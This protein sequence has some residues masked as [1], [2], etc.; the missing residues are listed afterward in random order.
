[1]LSYRHFKASDLPFMTRFNQDEEALAMLNMPAFET[2]TEK[3]NF[4]Q[5]LQDDQDAWALLNE[6]QL[7]GFVMLSPVYDE[8]TPTVETYEIAF[9]LLAEYRRQGLMAQFLKLINQYYQKEH[10][11][12]QLQAT[13]LIENNAAQALLKKFGFQV[14]TQLTL[15]DYVGHY[16]VL[17]WTLKND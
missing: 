7:V 13:T 3:Q 6:Q 8:Q 12:L 15:P 4:L 14:T 5:M 11:D 2:L 16:E 9:Y 17:V 1:M 10:G